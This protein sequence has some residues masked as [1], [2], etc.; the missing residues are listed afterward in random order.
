[1][2]AELAGKKIIFIVGGPGSGKGTQCERI[3][4][5]YGYCHL[6]SGDLLRAEVA[7]GSERG[8]ELQEIMKR[9]ELV[10]LETVLAMIRDKMLANTDAKG[11]LIDGYPRE[12]DQGK[13]FESSIASATSVLYL[14]VAT[15]TMVQRLIKRG[16]TSG[17]ADDNEETIRARLNTFEKAT[18]PV[19]D[20][21]KQQGKL[22][23]IERSV[24]E[25]SPDDVFAKVCL[26]FDKL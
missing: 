20:F 21:Y 2:A 17:R 4:A 13:Q 23:E 25:S 24:A 14:D 11:F 26:L 19:V 18:A 5:K 16:Q 8:Q 7:S 1:M 6:S 10:P 3:V 15:E 9:G 22:F 12:V